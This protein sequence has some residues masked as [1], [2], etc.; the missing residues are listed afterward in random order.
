M[1]F[2]EP[3]NNLL[4]QQSKVK[5]LRFLIKSQAG[6]SGREIAR[7]I[8][9]T[10]RITHATLTELWQYGIVTM[11]RVGKAKLYQI[12][13][14]SLFVAKALAPLFSFEANLLKQVASLIIKNL[15]GQ[16]VSIIIFGS[17]AEGKE[18]GGS[19]LDLLIVMKEGT[20]LAKIESDL[21][22]LS[23]IISTSFGNQISPVLLKEKQFSR[24]Y[25]QK[26]PFV[27]NIVARGKTIYGKTFMEMAY[28]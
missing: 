21:D 8:G 4:G 24:K 28:A 3:L 20:D 22:R 2:K 25:K 26:D 23:A 11:R 15:K 5:A 6:L 10:Q 14:E 19:D 16:V 9:L 18:E 12:N 27:R 7:A 13:K 17:I 1:R